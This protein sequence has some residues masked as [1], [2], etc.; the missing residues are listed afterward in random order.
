MRLLLQ[1]DENGFKHW[2]DLPVMDKGMGMH[3]GDKFTIAGVRRSVPNPDRRWWQ[4]WK[5]RT[6][7]GPPMEFT[8][9][10]EYR[11]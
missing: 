9:V 10:G 1:N 6:V 3:V 5:P 8:C 4:W 7:P 2:Q 11:V